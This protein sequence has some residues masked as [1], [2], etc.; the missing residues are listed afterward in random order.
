[1]RVFPFL[2]LAISILS[3]ATTAA[4]Q[5]P[6]FG[7]PAAAPPKTAPSDRV[8]TEKPV[9]D[10]KGPDAQPAGVSPGDA[11][12][13]KEGSLKPPKSMTTQA[14]H[15]S[16]IKERPGQ[17]TLVVH[18][19]WKVHA[20]ASM[21]VRLLP[22][23]RAAKSTVSPLY[24]FSEYFQGP[25]RQKVFRC[26]DHADGGATDSFTKDNLDFRIVGTRNSLGRSTVMVFPFNPKTPA[27]RQDNDAWDSPTV[28]FPLL[29]SW[30]VDDRTLTLDLP[31]EVSYRAERD[32]FE[33]T[34]KAFSR[35]GKLYVWFLRGEKVI[36]EDNVDW[37]GH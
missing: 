26:L 11:P 14:A 4:A 7:R 29:E 10:V 8:G 22:G 2:P 9:A 16:I 24:F 21:E 6:T 23:A 19:L 25:A 27:D 32:K 13:G 37:P 3:W 1:M 28:L 34:L 31:R 30:A 5:G 33:R 15:V 36:W 20:Q 35:P 18:Y 17:V 12:L